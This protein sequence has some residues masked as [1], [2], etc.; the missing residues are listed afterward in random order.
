MDF[1]L[2]EYENRLER[3]HRM[4]AAA[5][6]DALFCT[7]E[8]EMRYFTGFRSLFWQS[9]TRPWHLIVPADGA[10]IVVIPEIG[11]AAMARTWIKDIRTWASPAADDDGVTLAANAL[12]GRSRIGMPMGRETQLRMPLLDFDRLRAL[13]PGSVFED[14]TAI[15]QGLRMVKSKAEIAYLARIAGIASAAFA[16][17]P[18]LFHAGQPLDEA[19]RAFRIELLRQGAEDAP[20]VV[21]GAGPLGQDDIISPADG[22]PLRRGD[23]LMLDT[24]AALNG[25]FSDFDRNFAILAAGDA[26]SGAHRTLWAATEAGL[27]A[28]RPGASAADVHQAMAAVI[29]AGD[30]GVGRMGHGLGMQLTEPPSLIAFDKTPLQAGMVI[31]L[32]PS[33]TVP[34]GKTLVHEETIVIEDGPPRLLS[35][36]T[37]PELPVIG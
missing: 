3:A 37:P 30:G 11:A 31:T 5:G 23:V 18:R 15:V 2:S 34:G 36:R 16:E 27:S 10:P 9:P 28:A 25:Y 13:L 7:T 33:M 24:G 35:A 20:Y 26:V 12:N 6:L 1:A 21:G 8:A 32:E 22:T 19:F 29:G 4:M 17:A 14:A